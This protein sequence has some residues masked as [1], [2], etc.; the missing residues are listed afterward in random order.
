MNSKLATKLQM[1]YQIYY[2]SSKTSIIN[3]LRGLH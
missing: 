3:T 2:N 1:T